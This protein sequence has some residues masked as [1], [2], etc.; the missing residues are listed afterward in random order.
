M[1]TQS[2]QLLECNLSCRIERL[3]VTEIRRK[4]AREGHAHLYRSV[5]EHSGIHK[6]SYVGVKS[7]TKLTPEKYLSPTALHTTENPKVK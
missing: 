3:P 4:N 5:F 7:N 1:Q 2:V 6:F